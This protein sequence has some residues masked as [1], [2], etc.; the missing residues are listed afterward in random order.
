MA[1]TVK[2]KNFSKED[3]R[4]MIIGLDIPNLTTDNVWFGWE[5]K[6]ADILK[7]RGNLF[8]VFINYDSMKYNSVPKRTFTITDTGITEEVRCWKSVTFDIRVGSVN[9]RDCYNEY[10]MLKTLLL[11]CEN[12]IILQ[13]NF[14][15]LSYFDSNRQTTCFEYITKATFRYEEIITKDTDIQQLKDLKIDTQIINKTT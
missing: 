6:E 11:G 14:N 9:N 2:I 7:Q 4:K 5:F 10:S 12:S 8:N 15:S 3:V 13:D 1:N